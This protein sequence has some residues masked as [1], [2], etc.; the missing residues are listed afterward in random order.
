MYIVYEA[1][2]LEHLLFFF[3]LFRLEWESGV[4]R[5]C[6]V[7]RQMEEE[8]LEQLKYLAVHYQSAMSEHRPKLLASANRLEEPIRNC[9]VERDIEP[10]NKKVTMHE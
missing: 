2:V 7:F 5:G 10:V 3:S 4:L 8:R 1:R 6:S 9:D